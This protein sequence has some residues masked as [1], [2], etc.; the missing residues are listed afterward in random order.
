MDVEA[1]HRM[2]TEVTQLVH[3]SQTLFSV[4]VVLSLLGL[5]VLGW[6]T[7]AIRANSREVA[8]ITAAALRQES[9]P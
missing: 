1:V 4:Q 8:T 5:S 2:T 6:H 3:L 9:G 7:C